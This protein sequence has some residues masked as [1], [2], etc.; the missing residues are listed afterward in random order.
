VRDAFVLVDRQQ[1]AKERL[2]RMGINM[3]AALTLEVILN[4]LKFN[5]YIEDAWYSKSIR[6]LEKNRGENGN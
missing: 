3:R 4:A 1:G 5:G 6:Y 2:R